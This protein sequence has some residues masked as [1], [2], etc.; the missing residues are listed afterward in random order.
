[1]HDLILQGIY[2]GIPKVQ[3]DRLHLRLAGLYNDLEPGLR[4]R[5]LHRA[6]SWR[7]RVPSCKRSRWKW[8]AIGMSRPSSLSQCRAIDY[9]PKDEYQLV[10]LQGQVAVATGRIQLAREHFEASRTFAREESQRI[11][12]DLW[13]ARVLNMLDALEA[14]ETILDGLLPLAEALDD[15]LPL[16]ETLYLK[17]SLYFPGAILPPA[18]TIIPKLSYRRARLAM[19]APKS[20]R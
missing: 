3:R 8:P 19:C 10:L 17:G 13:L 18:A 1:M 2:E 11:A 4:A 16:A 12:A 9:A 15:P 5:H 20:R 14:E 7:R 6:R